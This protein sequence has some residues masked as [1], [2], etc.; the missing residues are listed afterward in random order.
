MIF[1]IGTHVKN[2][3]LYSSHS[4]VSNIETSIKS[5][6]QSFDHM[7]A[8]MV[9]IQQDLLNGSVGATFPSD[10]HEKISQIHREVS[11]HS[12]ANPARPDPSLDDRL[13]KAGVRNRHRLDMAC[14]CMRNHLSF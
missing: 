2:F 6:R 7:N 13:Q 1:M 10:V 8:K 4:K 12:V 9:Q 5:H 11:A 3:A 14:I